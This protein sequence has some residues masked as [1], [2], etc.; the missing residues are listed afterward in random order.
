V[1]FDYDESMPLFKSAMIVHLDN[2]STIFLSL[3]PKAD[4][5]AFDA[6]RDEKQLFAAKT[7]GDNIYWPDGPRLTL[8]EIMEMLRADGGGDWSS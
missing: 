7:D 4:D 1:D 2:N 3:E 8:D 6:L 5:A